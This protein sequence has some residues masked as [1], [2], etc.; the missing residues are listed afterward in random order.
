MHSHV[1][2]Y[3]G[4][5]VVLAGLQGEGLHHGRREARGQ[6]HT[7]HASLRLGNAPIF[8]QIPWHLHSMLLIMIA[9]TYAVL[10]LQSA[11]WVSSVAVSKQAE[12]L[13]IWPCSWGGTS[14]NEVIVIHNGLQ[15]VHSAVDVLLHA[16]HPRT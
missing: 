6:F 2:I 4:H 16:P 8:Q 1:L 3:A 9:P 11:Q 14:R 10:L 13:L 15:V 5:A 7:C 12:T